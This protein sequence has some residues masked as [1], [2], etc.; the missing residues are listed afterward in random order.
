MQALHHLMQRRA[1]HQ[2]KDRAAEEEIRDGQLLQNIRQPSMIEEL[3]YGG[4][5]G[6]SGD[7]EYRKV[8]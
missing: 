1:H 8:L 2:S 7:L 6:G 4:F 5:L 3:C